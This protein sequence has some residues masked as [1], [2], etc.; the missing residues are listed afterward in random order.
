MFVDES[1]P[2]NGVQ[3]ISVKHEEEIPN[4]K[5]TAPNAAMYRTLPKLH[6]ISLE[7]FARD[8]YYRRNYRIYDSKDSFSIFKPAESRLWTT[9]AALS[10]AED[11]IAELLQPKKVSK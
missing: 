8:M 11:T 9:S 5:L 2:I 7:N 1:L 4:I 6:Q 3:F 10:D